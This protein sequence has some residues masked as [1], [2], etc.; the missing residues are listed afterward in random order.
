MAQPIDQ[1]LDQPRTGI[2]HR[3]AALVGRG[4]SYLV[5][6]VDDARARAAL[7]A[8]FAH[9]EQLG[10]LDSVLSDLGTARTEVPI[11]L[12]NHPGAARRLAAMLHRLRIE[13]APEA[14]NSAE[15]RM[16]QRTCAL[17]AASG[18]CNRWLRSEGSEDPSHFCPNAA[19]FLDLLVKRK[20]T[21]RRGA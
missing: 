6:A 7:R 14:R 5:R 18:R 2:C 1:P 13:V 11:L 15:M 4:K 20:A 12:K 17:C 8:E 16:I 9:L 19:A 21:Y 10:A 3:F